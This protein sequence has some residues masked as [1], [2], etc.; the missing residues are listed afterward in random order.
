VG[1]MSR[2][3][4]LLPVEASR[5]RVSQSSLKIGGGAMTGGARDT[6]ADVA[7]SPS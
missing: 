4:G 5:V 6:I 7:L 1:H 3:S 2:S